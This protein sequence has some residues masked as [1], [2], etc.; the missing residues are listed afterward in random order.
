MGFPL[1]RVVRTCQALN[2]DDS[3]Q[4]INFCLLVNKFIEEEGFKDES[5]VEHVLLMKSADEKAAK[6]HLQ[7]FTQLKE[8]G[9]DSRS[10][11]D[12]LLKCNGD[13]DKALEQL[14]KF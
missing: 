3:R 2:T 7:K 1:A 11:H 9:F 13:K 5:E 10:I 6:Q 8:F 4:I 12:A 14:L